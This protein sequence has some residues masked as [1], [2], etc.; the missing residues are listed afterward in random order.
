VKALA[1][2]D[3]TTNQALGLVREFILPEATVFTDEY[4]IYDRLGGRV[5]EHKRINH[6]AKVYVMGDVHTNTI[7]G[8]WSLVKR[9]I[10]GVYHQVSQKYLQTYLDEYSFRYNRRDQGNLIFT[11]I[12]K[13]VAELA[14][15]RVAVDRGMTP[16]IQ[17]PF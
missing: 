10:G 17:E 15:P 11:S 6:G 12:L 3:V 1:T 16:V 8:F 13:R 7:E 14:S 4:A 2:P 5:N 9:G